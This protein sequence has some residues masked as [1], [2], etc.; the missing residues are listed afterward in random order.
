MNQ[1][2]NLIANILAVANAYCG[3]TGLSRSRVATIVFN[4]GKKL[5]LIARGA[6]LN[7]RR[8]EKAMLWFS[9]NWPE[10]LAWPTGIERPKHVDLDDAPLA[11]NGAAA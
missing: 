7:T 4:D 9:A 1:A 11:Q 8:Y 2:M 3:H 6:D 10:A 5:D